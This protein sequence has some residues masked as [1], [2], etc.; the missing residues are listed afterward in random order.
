MKLYSSNNQSVDQRY[1]QN[2]SLT[3]ECF[4]IDIQP[5]T[6]NKHKGIAHVAQLGGL[7]I[8]RIETTAAVVTRKKDTPDELRHRRYCFNFVLDGKMKIT[9]HM[10][11]T[12]LHANEFIMF[13]NAFA[14]TMHVTDAV[15][16]ITINV[17]EADLK[18][19]I[20][21]PEELLGIKI[22]DFELH[23]YTMM[24]QMKSCWNQVE[25]GVVDVFA[26]VIT[27]KLLEAI[28]ERYSASMSKCKKKS[29]RRVTQIIEIIEKNLDNPDFNVG[30][31]AEKAEISERYLR[32]L[33]AGKEKISHQILRRRLEECAR[34]LTNP[35]FQNVSIT[36]IAFQWGFN[37]SAH[38]SRA[39]KQQF[40]TSPRK[41][42]VV[43]QSGDANID[44]AQNSKIV[45]TGSLL[46]RMD[47]THH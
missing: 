16:I 31:L 2:Y 12:E 4:S 26:S 39:F 19:F 9:H 37:S 29:D 45:E 6:K 11:S 25:K 41:Y 47:S 28:A 38:F 23:G 18:R 21:K 20:P 22:F 34:Q 5:L 15:S 30:D 40:G 24:S 44:C 46:S 33:F 36:S 1:G 42:R 8:S 17:S 27:D 35:L 43:N 3:T 14:R 7:S 10:G 13:D 32:A